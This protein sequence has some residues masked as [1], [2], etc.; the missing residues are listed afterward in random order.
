MVVWAGAGSGGGVGVGGLLVERRVHACI[1]RV[2]HSCGE[3]LNPFARLR[4]HLPWDN[5]Y[6]KR[7]D[8]SKRQHALSPDHAHFHASSL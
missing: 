8:R 2:T 3:V 1:T 6:S 4:N 5:L 7:S